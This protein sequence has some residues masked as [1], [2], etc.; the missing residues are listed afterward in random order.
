[1]T[2]TSAARTAPSPS[3]HRQE[4]R[5]ARR[6][7]HAQNAIDT[8]RSCVPATRD[9]SGRAMAMRSTN[10]P[11]AASS[12]RNMIQRAATSDGVA[13]VSDSVGIMNCG[14]GPWFGPTAK[15]YAPRTGCPSA[16]ITRQHDEVPALA[17][18]LQRHVELV[19]VRRRTARRPGGELVRRRIG[20]RHDREPRLDRFAEDERDRLRRRA[21]ATLAAGT[22]CRSAACD[23]ATAGSASAAAATSTGA[24]RR[25]IDTC[26]VNGAVSTRPVHPAL[27]KQPPRRPATGRGRRR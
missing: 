24:A 20:H 5:R 9:T 7:V 19:D 17:Q 21:D 26:S 25:L 14:A 16:E 27:E 6:R 23:Q 15:V 12:E 18:R 10:S 4:W 8:A 2:R 3:A 1:M 11:I 13:A 22:V